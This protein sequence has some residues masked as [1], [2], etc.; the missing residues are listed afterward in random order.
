MDVFIR[1]ICLL[2]FAFLVGEALCGVDRGSLRPRDKD[3]EEFDI[4]SEDKTDSVDATEDLY[5]GNNEGAEVHESGNNS[6]V[7]ST[8]NVTN[9]GKWGDWGSVQ[10]C[11]DGSYAAG[12]DMKIEK[13]V[14]ADDTALNA[15]KLICE[16]PDGKETG[17]ITSTQGHWGSW[18]GQIKCPSRVRERLYLTSF[19]LQVQKPKGVLKDD[20]AANYVKFKCRD[21][22][23]RKKPQELAKPPGRGVWGSWGAWSAQCPPDTAICGLKTKVEK[24]QGWHRDDTALNDVEFY[25]CV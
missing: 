11:P 20:T 1:G 16:F 8:L 14:C 25:C 21:K 13:P 15:I 4:V 17:E 22:C 10:L 9:G 23:G 6:R 24:P 3:V 12:Y 19:D 18:V 2:T 7:I 5:A